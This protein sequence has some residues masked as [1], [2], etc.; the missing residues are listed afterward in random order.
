MSAQERQEDELELE[1]TNEPAHDETDRSPEDREQ[2]G[3]PLLPPQSGQRYRSA[4]DSIQVGF[5][6][7]PR[8]AVERADQL[9]AELM[10]ELAEGFAQARSSLEG[11]WGRGEEVS[12]EELRVALQRYRSFFQR[13]LAA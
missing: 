9:V 7:Q 4:W 10:R 8:K 12:T 11:E 1:S 6:D 2:S 5:V 13:L 3:R